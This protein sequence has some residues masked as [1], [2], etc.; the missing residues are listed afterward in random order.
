MSIKA[1]GG[2]QKDLAEMSAKNVSFLDGSPKVFKKKR[3]ILKVFKRSKF[4][5][6]QIKTLLL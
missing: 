5:R 6:I 3:T 1:L 2:G 4:G